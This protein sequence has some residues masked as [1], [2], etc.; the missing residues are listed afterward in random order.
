MYKNRLIGFSVIRHFDQLTDSALDEMHQAGIDCLELSFDTD[1]YATMNLE[2]IVTTA[3]RNGVLIWSLHLPFYEWNIAPLEEAFRQKTLLHH[4]DLISRAGRAGI[5]KVILHCC[6]EPVEDITR[7]TQLKTACQSLKELAAVAAENSVQICIEDLPR[8]CLGNCS[9][10]ILQMLSADE[11][12]GVCF[13]TN[14]LLKQDNLDFV[15]A[16]GN[17]IC[18][19]HISD[20]D[21]M[22]ERHWL[23]GEG[24]IAWPELMKAIFAT[25]YSGPVMF[26]V[27]RS[28]ESTLVRPRELTFA[29]YVNCAKALIDSKQPSAVGKRREHLGM[30]GVEES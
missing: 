27:D 30:W 24:D 14:H 3:N 22:N 23:P 9:D 5:R 8:T 12:L 18:S 29:D 16:V 28:C 21:F 19:V 17:R 6:R 4:C 25:G 10:E 20:F 11:R 26:E 15:K 2:E 7:E 13:D 1:H